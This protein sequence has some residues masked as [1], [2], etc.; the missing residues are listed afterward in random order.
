VGTIVGLP[1]RSECGPR[2]IESSFIKLNTGLASL[3]AVLSCVPT[4][5][6]VI[7]LFFSHS[8]AFS[9]ILVIATVLPVSPI[10]RVAVRNPMLLLRGIEEPRIK[11][12]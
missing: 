9:M 1:Y 6:L 7:A 12:D 3:S 10:I 8:G 11:V 2:I 5:P 4:T